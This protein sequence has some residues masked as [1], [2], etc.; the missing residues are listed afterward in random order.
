LLT[1]RRAAARAVP[2]CP[3]RRRRGDRAG[4]PE[5]LEKVDF[6]RPELAAVVEGDAR[7]RC[8][9]ERPLLAMVGGDVLPPWKPIVRHELSMPAQL[10]RA[11]VAEG[12]DRLAPRASETLQGSAEEPERLERTVG[13]WS[14]RMSGVGSPRCKPTRGRRCV[15]TNGAPET[16]GAPAA[17][18]LEGFPRERSASRAFS[19]LRSG[20]AGADPA[21]AA[22]SMIA[23]HRRTSPRIARG[24]RIS[25]GAVMLFLAA[26]S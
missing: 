7:G 4:A 13:W 21:V 8:P 1:A 20:S 2:T 17:A 16:K 18:C 14:C 24:M 11:I 19:E 15:L 5:R 23:S 26:T 12:I 9:R 25:A 10:R 6:A 22:S 3:S